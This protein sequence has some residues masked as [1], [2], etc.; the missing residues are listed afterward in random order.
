MAALIYGL[1]A[2]TAFACSALLLRSYARTRHRLLFWSG[3]CFAG[4]LV[5]NLLLVLDRVVLAGADLLV[6]R[7]VTALIALL[8]L[9]YGLIWDEE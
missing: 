6:W 8:P 3:L 5:N 4:M 1:C 9:L 2:L 7:Q